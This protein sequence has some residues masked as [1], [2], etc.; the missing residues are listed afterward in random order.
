M[1][2]VSRK[3]R[4]FGG[5]LSRLS[6]TK[7]AVLGSMAMIVLFS[8]S[9]GSFRMY[10]YSQDDPAFCR[11]CHTMETAWDK[12]SNSEHSKVNCHSCHEVSP[13]AGAELVINYLIEKPDRNTNHATVPDQACKNCHY[14]GD[15]EWVQ[16]ASTAG[17][18]VHAQQNNI[19][20]QTCHGMLLHRF[21][22][23]TD[24]CYACHPDQVKGQQQEIKVPQMQEL[25]CQECHQ[26]LRENSPLRPTRETCLS[27]HQK[28]P[29][30]S[31]TFPDNA[32]MKWDCS[33]CHKPH[34]AAKPTVDCNSCHA[35]VR[36]EG[37]HAASTHSR[38]ACQ[39]CHKPHEWKVTSRDKCLTCHGDKAR[40]NQGQF[41]GGCHSF[42]KPAGAAPTGA[43]QAQ[44]GS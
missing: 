37:L 11:Q 6:V 14:S 12:W 32:P 8:G 21:K 31:V 17:H 7:K 16:V 18:R 2:W 13:I 36:T 26:F 25:H 19:A 5:R 42:R 38:T 23:A 3:A 28:L 34:E 33:E 39:T 10:S 1:R 20:C 29:S 22:P 15:P 43:G 44:Y 27:C 9:Y 24:I 41:C 40:H 30:Q 4:G 35:Q